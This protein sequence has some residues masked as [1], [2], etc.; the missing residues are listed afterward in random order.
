[1]TIGVIGYGRFGRF[2]VAHLARR[3]DVVVFDTRRVPR[4]EF[5]KRARKG[6]LAEAAGQEV[7]LLAVPVSALRATL[8][9]IRPHLRRGALIV[10]V[11][12]VKSAPLRWMKQILPPDAEILGTHPFFGPDS[13]VSGLK[14]LMVV[15]S[16]IRVRGRTLSRVLTELHRAGLETVF[17]SPAEHDRL[18]AETILLTQYVGRLVHRLGLT[19]WPPVT[20]NY[21][22]LCAIVRTVRNDTPELLADMIAYNPFGRKLI[23]EFRK[24]Q[25]E[26]HRDLKK[27]SH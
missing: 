19:P 9:R 13:G 7:V 25:R 24:A 21:E 2:A 15:L 23:A 17:M 4:A 5:P 8:R 10:D 22:R 27:R 6:G 26:L 1:M 14:G 20:R 18:M 11:A 3:A 12:A 16:P